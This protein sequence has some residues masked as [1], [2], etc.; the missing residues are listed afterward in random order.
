[1][2]ILL[3]P[4]GC[5][6][7]CCGPPCGCESARVLPSLLGPSPSGVCHLSRACSSL[8][9]LV[10]VAHSFHPS[11]L[12]GGGLVRSGGGFCCRSL[13]WPERALSR[14]LCVGLVDW[15]PSLVRVSLMRWGVSPCVWFRR[16]PWGVAV[17]PPI[18]PSTGPGWSPPI[19]RVALELRSVFPIFLCDIPHVS[20]AI[21]LSVSLTP[22]CP[23]LIFTLGAVP[24]TL[25]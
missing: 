13:V 2:T 23:Y 6:C 11:L 25:A 12:L 10:G 21:I 20:M 5:R 16:D 24:W 1:M 9:G 15:F 22:A 3:A 19:C 8:G 7:A 18:S 14:F 17:A 4:C